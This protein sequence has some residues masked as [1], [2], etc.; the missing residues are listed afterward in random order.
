[1]AGYLRASKYSKHSFESH[2]IQTQQPTCI[3]AAIKTSFLCTPA[4]EA[5]LP[6]PAF[7][8]VPLPPGSIVLRLSIGPMSFYHHLDTPVFFF[9]HFFG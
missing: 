3:A 5:P 9:F 8:S 1:M 6:R 7:R 2:T 4:P